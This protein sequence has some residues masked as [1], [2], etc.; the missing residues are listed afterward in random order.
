MSGLFISSQNHILSMF[1][2]FVFALY[3]GNW[4]VLAKML[5]IICS[6]AVWTFQMAKQTWSPHVIKIKCMNICEVKW[7]QMKLKAFSR[8]VQHNE[9][10]CNGQI[11]AGSRS[12]SHWQATCPPLSILELLEGNWK[13]IAILKTFVHSVSL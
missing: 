5:T 8:N 1:D 9:M 11:F 3:V 2:Y 10:I 6:C 12:R 4:N 7:N 13:L